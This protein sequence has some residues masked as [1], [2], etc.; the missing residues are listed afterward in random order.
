MIDEAKLDEMKVTAEVESG[1]IRELW[2]KQFKGKRVKKNGAKSVNG[3]EK[4]PGANGAVGQ[5]G[6][7]EAQHNPGAGSQN[8]AQYPAGPGG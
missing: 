8:P 3:Q 6:Q 1:K 7:E 5:L 2:V 4:A